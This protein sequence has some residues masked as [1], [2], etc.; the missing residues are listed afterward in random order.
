MQP[1]DLWHLLY[2]A[3][4]RR[5]HQA[6]DRR[7]HVQC[8]VRSPGVIIG[9]LTPVDRKPPLSSHN[10]YC[11]LVPDWQRDEVTI[12]LSHIAGLM[13]GL[14]D[15][16]MTTHYGP[17]FDVKIPSEPSQTVANCAVSTIDAVG[18]VLGISLGGQHNLHVPHQEGDASACV[19]SLTEVFGG[20]WL[21]RASG[22]SLLPR[23]LDERAG[24]DVR[25]P[26]QFDP[27]MDPSLCDGVLRQA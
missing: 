7:V 17:V 18:T 26:R 1:T 3:E 19:T 4:F 6:W 15:G 13:A 16:Q 25:R 10:L 11:Q 8:P 24:Q 12:C 23:R 22:L 27:E 2:G 20:M 21:I 9:V 5:L 14:R